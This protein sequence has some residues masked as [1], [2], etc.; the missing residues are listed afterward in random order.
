MLGQR[1]LRRHSLTFECGA[2]RRTTTTTA[3]QGGN[4]GAK[5]PDGKAIFASAG[6][7][8]C[9]TLKDAGAK[10][11]VGPNLDS[12]KPSEQA[13]EQQVTNGGGGMPPF[14]DQL[15]AAQI[16]AVAQYVSSVAGK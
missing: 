7:A 6:C 9:H 2:R 1:Q 4:G 3:T 16:K 14:K 11:N 5:G 13:T 15:T 8:S 12:L 10:G